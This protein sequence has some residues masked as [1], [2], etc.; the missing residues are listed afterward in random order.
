MGA[1]FLSLDLQKK[2]LRGEILVIVCLD[3]LK[4]IDLANKL[5]PGYLQLATKAE[6]VRMRGQRMGDFT[7]NGLFIRANVA[8]EVTFLGGGFRDRVL[9]DQQRPAQLLA[10]H[11]AMAPL[12]TRE[13]P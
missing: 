5:Q 12:A 13:Q 11:L 6:T 4:M 1:T 2:I 8:G 7:L 9:F 10:Q 3:I